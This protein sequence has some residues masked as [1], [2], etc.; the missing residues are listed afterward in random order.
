MYHAIK[1]NSIILSAL[2]VNNKKSMKAVQE[3]ALKGTILYSVPLYALFYRTRRT[4]MVRFRLVRLGQF[5]A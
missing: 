3:L 4:I 5:R 1:D 2:S